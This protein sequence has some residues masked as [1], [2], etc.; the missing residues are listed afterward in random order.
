MNVLLVMPK[1]GY[2][3]DEWA[4]PPIGIAYVSAYLKKH[5]V[6]VYNVNL[7]LEDDDVEAVLSRHIEQYC[8]DIMGTGEL[9]VNYKKLQEI[10]QIGRRIKPEMKIWIGGGLVTNSPYEAMKLIPEADYGMIGEGEITALELI[11]V[12]DSNGNMEIES[13]DGLIIRRPGGEL[14]CTPKRKDIEDLDS[15][16]FPDWQGFRLVETCQKYAKGGEGITASLVSSRS[17]PNSCTFCSKS[18]GKNYRKRSLDNIFSEI[19]ELIHTYHVTRLNFNDELFASNANRLYEFCDRMEKYHIT[20]RVS[21][22]VSK[23]LTLDLLRRMRESGCEVIFFGL[24]SADNSVLKSMRKHTTIEEINE[25]LRLTKMAGIK[26]EGNFIFGDPAETKESVQTTMQWIKQNYNMGLFEVAAIKLYPGS[27]LYEDAV[28]NET[29]KDTVQF[30]ADGCPLTNVSSLEDADYWKLVNK[31][32][33]NIIHNSTGE[34]GDVSV[35]GLGDKI[36]G[37]VRCS[38]CGEKIL[39]E[40]EDP[41]KL[42]HMYPRHCPGCGAI[43]YINLFPAYYKLASERLRKL[44]KEHHLAVFGCGNIWKLFYAAGDI[45]DHF[46]Y[47]I[48]DETPFLQESGWN[49][50]RVYSPDV[51]EAHGIDV[52]LV[53]IRVSKK[54]VVEKIRGKYGMKKV[55][56]IMCYDL[57]NPNEVFFGGGQPG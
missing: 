35:S 9:V 3:W 32:L 26:V 45:F 37:E 56:I 50:H 33:T 57:L 12:L 13:V 4:T 10:V 46:D 22:H 24:E 36:T 5:G 21:M 53:M 15:I 11:K 25:C 39:F 20:Y 52:L 38:F 31:D 48:I 54:E 51:I 6:S 1:T 44:I 43:E 23:K 8:I 42:L 49:N 18:G 16:P 19:E 55:H 47:E 29:I 30:I 40:V 34:E 41:V 27:Q 2:L 7:N 17:C 14:F 28:A